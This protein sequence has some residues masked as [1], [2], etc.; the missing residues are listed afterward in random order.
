MERGTWGSKRVLYVS[1]PRS[2]SMSLQPKQDLVNIQDTRE[3]ETGVW[4]IFLFHNKHQTVLQNL[5]GAA[6]EQYNVAKAQ[7]RLFGIQRPLRN[8][9]PAHWRLQRPGLGQRAGRA[10]PPQ[11]RPRE[12]EEWSRPRRGPSDPQPQRPRQQSL[13]PQSP[14]LP[15]LGTHR[16]ELRAQ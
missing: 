16:G 12:R 6:L 8:E 3:D 10:A 5:N 15:H 7:V 11:A 2:I 9:P 4:Y 14:S 13:R 1:K